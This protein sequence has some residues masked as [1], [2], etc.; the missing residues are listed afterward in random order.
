MHTRTFNLRGITWQYPDTGDYMFAAMHTSQ[1]V[2]STL[3][4]ERIRLG[5]LSK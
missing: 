4:F 1:I 5:T 2:Y 3:S